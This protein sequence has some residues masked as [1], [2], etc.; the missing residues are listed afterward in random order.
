MNNRKSSSKWLYLAL[1]LTVALGV[2][3]CDR[4]IVYHHY[5]H[6]PLDGWEKEDTLTFTV[7]PMSQRTVMRGD[8]ELRIDDSYPFRS[9]SLIV[10]QTV[11]PACH[12]RRDTVDCRFT[13]PDGNML[14]QGITLYQYR[15]PLSDMTL[16]E[17]DS[18]CL[19]VYHNM[20]RETL[21]GI[22]NIG[23]RLTAY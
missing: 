5:E 20:R 9:L 18:L 14:G 19:R 22:A 11:W 1:F 2:S 4:K 16:E 21:T 13:T 8:V 6:T 10:E 7:R 3:S 17:D 15:F 23:I 12:V